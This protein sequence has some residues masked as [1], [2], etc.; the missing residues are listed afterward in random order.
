ML[1][2]FFLSPLVG[3]GVMAVVFPIVSFWNFGSEQLVSCKR[4]KNKFY[5]GH[6]VIR[7]PSIL[8]H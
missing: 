4:L 6:S 8:L 2:T 7:P 1:A 5:K 3:G